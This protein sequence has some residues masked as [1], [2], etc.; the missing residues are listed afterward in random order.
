MAAYTVY[1]CDQF[2]RVVADASDFTNLTYTRVVN[3]VGGLV[4][5]L[6]GDYPLNNIVSPDGRIQVWRRLSSGREYLDTDTT[7]LIKGY[8]LILDENGTRSIEVRALAPLCVLS[9]PGR[10]V[11]AYAGSAEAQK[12]GAADDM[13]K[14]IVREQASSSAAAARQYGGLISV[15]ANTAQ[16]PGI[17]KGFAWRDVLKVLQELADASAQAGT[18]LA[19]DI[20]A[21]TTETLE[22]QTFVGQR[23]IDHRFPGGVNPVL[24]GPDFGTMGACSLDYDWEEEATYAKAGGQGEGSGRLTGED[25]DDARAAVSPFG[26]REVFVSATNYATSTGL[27]AEAEAQVRAQRPR[28]ILNGELLDSP[29]A[30]YG[31]DW[32]WGDYLTIQVFGVSIDARVQAVT[33]EASPGRERIRAAVRGEL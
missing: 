33:V 32:A 15:A 23:G 11:D 22:F 3:D 28:V 18:Y 7:W 13:C 5:T 9:E 4:L 8:R 31:Q 21:P 2:G 17:T 27:A 24:I 14:A 26:R 16:A 20:V 10:F 12:T 1:L 25:L 19:F 29:Q 30:R 6:K